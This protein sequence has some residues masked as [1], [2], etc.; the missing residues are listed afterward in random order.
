MKQLLEGNE[1]LFEVPDCHSTGKAPVVH[2]ENG[3]TLDEDNCFSSPT[4][5]L[6]SAASQQ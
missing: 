1:L 4:L 5:I 2:L 3:L 6:G